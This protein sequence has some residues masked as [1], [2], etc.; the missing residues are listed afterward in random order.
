MRDGIR[1]HTPEATLYS[2]LAGRPQGTLRAAAL[3]F[4]LKALTKMKIGGSEGESN[5]RL[6]AHLCCSKAG[7]ARHGL[8]TSSCVFTLKAGH[9]LEPRVFTTEGRTAGGW[10]GGTPGPYK[11]L[12]GVRFHWGSGRTC[13]VP[14]GEDM[15]AREWRRGSPHPSCPPGPVALGPKIASSPQVNFARANPAPHP[16]KAQPAPLRPTHASKAF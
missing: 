7:A 4:G 2:N 13:P 12:S 10:A 5:R 1:T 14:R 8:P 16:N 3:S 9:S 6:K 15:M 11:V